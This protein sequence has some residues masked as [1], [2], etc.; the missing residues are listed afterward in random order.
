MNAT[1]RAISF[2]RIDSLRLAPDST[3]AR[4][5]QGQALLPALALMCIASCIGM[6]FLAV[7]R[8][9]SHLAKES[10]SA[11]NQALRKMSAVANLLNQVALNNRR[12]IGALGKAMDAHAFATDLSM[13]TAASRSFTQN[14]NRSA[15]LYSEDIGTIYNAMGRTSALFVRL[16]ESFSRSNVEL[17]ATISTNLPQLAISLQSLDAPRTWCLAHALLGPGLLRRDAKTNPKASCSHRVGMQNVFNYGERVA[18][19]NLTQTRTG[20]LY[21]PESGVGPFLSALASNR[22]ESRA[23][24][25]KIESA[26]DTSSNFLP[27]SLPKVVPSW[28]WRIAIIHPE[29]KASCD[30]EQPRLRK[31][32]SRASALSFDDLAR[33][34]AHPDTF[35]CLSKAM[36]SPR[37]AAVVSMEGPHE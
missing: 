2:A 21:V 30:P 18:Q 12:I 16:A 6:F 17:A 25:Q 4:N 14:A 31:T 26:G 10:E 29:L 28:T 27:M 36:F 24:P 35:V 15:S 9:A 8:H 1:G 5:R 22:Q 37:W 33:L 23:A 32:P 13:E 19:W 20:V 3:G 34:K 11:R 7:A